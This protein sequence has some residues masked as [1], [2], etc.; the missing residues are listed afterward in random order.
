[1]ATL[2]LLLGALL[3]WGDHFLSPGPSGG[4]R[5]L[6]ALWPASRPVEEGS[7]APAPA[8]P[9]SAAP[10]AESEGAP[11]ADAASVPVA[12]S[13]PAQV[14]PPPV[15]PAE[16]RAV[17]PS[18]PR[19]ALDLGS[20]P[21]AEDAERVERLLNQAGFS[22]IRFRQQGPAR[23]YTVLIP[24]LASPEEAQ[25]AL[26]RLRQDGFGDAVALAR[27]EGI[28]VRVAQA[29]PLRLA[30]RIAE[31]LRAAGHAARLTAEPGRPVHITLR[32]GNYASRQEAGAASD[33]VAR[34]GVPN[35]IV[36]VK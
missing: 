26:T 29:L 9:G 18:G 33:E 16:P 34:L 27:P 7:R 11:A 6:L 28:A 23:L 32:H 13:Q 22:T 36:R 1:L 14:E 35:E 21:L 15:P 19:Y 3:A 31:R 8:P 2:V 10:S 4:I 30:V 5:G 25:A 20:F 12:P 24:D 17:T